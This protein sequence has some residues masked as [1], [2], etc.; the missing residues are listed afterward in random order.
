MTVKLG[1]FNDPVLY[2]EASL[3]SEPSECFMGNESDICQVHVVCVFWL[4]FTCVIFFMTAI[5]GYK[6]NKLFLKFQLIPT[7]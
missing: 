4:T 5:R 6:Q 7:L 3:F 2:M 1:G